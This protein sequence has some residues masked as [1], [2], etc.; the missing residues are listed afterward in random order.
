MEVSALHRYAPWTLVFIVFFCFSCAPKE[1]LGPPRVEAPPKPAKVALVLGAG[2]SKGFAHVGVLKVL[3]INHVPIHLIVGTSVGSVVGSLYAHGY[4]AFQVQEI[5]LA[6]EKGDVIDPLYVPTQGFVKGEKLEEFVNKMVKHT[7]IEKLKISFLAV[8]TDVQQGQEVTLDKGNTGSAV[9]ASCS[10]PGVFRPAK[11]G[12]K[13]YVDGGVMSPVPVAAAKRFGA[14]VVIAVDIS[15]EVE[16]TAPQGTVETILQAITIMYANLS[17]IQLGQADVVIRP[18]VGHIGTFDFTKRHEAIL[19]GEKA[20]LAVM[21][22]VTQILGR[23]RQE[24]RL[25]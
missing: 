11:I 10:I 16:K 18:K 8:T 19:A 2:S 1:I 25:E 9:R 17:A 7:P 6:V 23:L 22:Q 20:T 3:E 4:S 12:D 5:A 15:S 14:D 21:P 24:G 13:V